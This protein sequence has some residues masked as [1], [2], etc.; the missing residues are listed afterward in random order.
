MELFTQDEKGRKLIYAQDLMDE[1]KKLK[2][3]IER[4]KLYLNIA[5]IDLEDMHDKDDIASHALY[6]VNQILKELA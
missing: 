3:Q 4:L 1:N 2:G 6:V 5:K